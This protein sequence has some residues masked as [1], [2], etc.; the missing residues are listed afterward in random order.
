M[1]YLEFVKAAGKTYVYVTEYVGEQENTRK[2][3]RRIYTL[4]RKQK[5]LEKLMKWKRE[6]EKI[7]FYIG[8]DENIIIG[9]WIKK[10]AERG[11]Y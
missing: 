2:K 6:E 11:A 4:G 10:V 8:N 5:A 3:E 1:A 9:K 7:P